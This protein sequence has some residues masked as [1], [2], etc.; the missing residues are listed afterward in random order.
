MSPAPRCRVEAAGGDLLKS[1]RF[2]TSGPTGAEGSGS[3][4]KSAETNYSVSTHFGRTIFIQHHSF[5]LNFLGE[6]AIQSQKT[7]MHGA[8]MHN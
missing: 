3:K 8:S 4:L 7:I 1:G 6:E 5:F 2:C